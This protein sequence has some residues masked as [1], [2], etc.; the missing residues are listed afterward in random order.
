MK[1]QYHKPLNDALQ[2]YK[3]QRFVTIIF[4]ESPFFGQQGLILKEKL[5]RHSDLSLELSSDNRIRIDA[6][7]TDYFG[8]EPSE[9][10]KTVSHCVDLALAQPI[11]QFIE[12]LRAKQKQ[13]A[14]DLAGV[15]AE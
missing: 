15:K 6:A 3:R 9:N 8:A 2:S 5:G 12:D 10:P 13:E 4:K 7:W 11:I 1:Q 14:P